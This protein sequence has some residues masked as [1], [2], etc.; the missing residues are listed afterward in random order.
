[1]KQTVSAVS[2]FYYGIKIDKTLGQDL[3]HTESICHNTS[4]N[5][6]FAFS[7]A[8]FI[9]RAGWSCHQDTLLLKSLA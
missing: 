3:P 2:D 1:M 4:S 9:Y 5:H 6:L 7:Q 8:T